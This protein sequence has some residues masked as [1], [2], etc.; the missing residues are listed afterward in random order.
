M[1]FGIILPLAFIM[2]G[3]RGDASSIFQLRDNSPAEQNKTYAFN[4]VP[5]EVKPMELSPNALNRRMLRLTLSNRI[6]IAV[7]MDTETLVPIQCGLGEVKVAG[8]QIAKIDT[9]QIYCVWLGNGDLVAGLA[10]RIEGLFPIVVIEIADLFQR[11]R[12]GVRTI[13]K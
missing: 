11:R 12:P 1:R 2:F 9:S 6:Q 10:T 8:V 7:A 5:F 13:G 3:N 4:V